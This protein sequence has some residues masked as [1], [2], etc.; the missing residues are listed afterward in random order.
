MAN[1]LKE[2]LTGFGEG[3]EN[4]TNRGLNGLALGLMD[5]INPEAVRL[6]DELQERANNTGVG[7][8]QA[9]NSSAAEIAGGLY[10]ASKFI[11]IA[12]KSGLSG[13]KQLMLAG[14]LEESI[15]GAIN[16]DNLKDIPANVLSSGAVGTLMSGATG[17]LFNSLVSGANLLRRD[18]GKG[19]VYLK[20]KL[21]TDELNNLITEARETGRSLVEVADQKALN[22]LDKARLQTEE[23]ADIIDKNVGGIKRKAVDKADDFL[24]GIFST[25]QGWKTAEE[26]KEAADHASGVIFSDLY[27]LGDITKR[28]PDLATFI[29]GNDLVK[30]AI[31]SVKNDVRVPPEVRKLPYGDMQILERARQ[32]LDD[33]A[34]KAYISGDKSAIKDITAQKNEFLTQM[35]NAVPQYDKALRIYEQAHRLRES[36]DKGAQVFKRNVNPEKFAE[37]FKKLEEYEKD[38]MKLGLKDKIYEILGNTNTTGGWKVMTNKNVM[39]KIKTV[40]GEEEGQ[41]L[42][43]F[44]NHEVRRQGN[45]NKLLGGSK[46]AE[47]QIKKVPFSLI[48][49]GIELI[50]TFGDVGRKS[51]NKGIAKLMTSPNSKL[52]DKAAS[53]LDSSVNKA[54]L[55]YLNATPEVSAL[56]NFLAS[57]SKL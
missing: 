18:V 57:Q 30:S 6:K 3:V 9:I 10:P 21:G 31:R 11:N 46:T 24:D 32:R 50:N 36:V 7:G 43:D 37:D 35:Y 16:S 8:V 47:K 13:L 23:A 29:K 39:K 42:I 28:N 22:I 44:A 25:K 40:L 54:L 52:A 56:A 41:K 20:E 5:K 26:V 49:T 15:R 27:Q 1:Y 45:I 34:T 51:R 55:R 53:S 48:N 33:M 12:G 4:A 2:F 38:A 17:F 14:G 19:I